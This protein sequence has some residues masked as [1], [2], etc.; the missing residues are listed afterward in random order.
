MSDADARL[1]FVAQQLGDHRRRCAAAGVSWPVTL[2]AAY[3]VASR[4]QPAPEIPEWTDGGENSLMTYAD[5]AARLAISERSL[6]RLIAAGH[7]GTVS[8][9]GAVRVRA[10]DLAAY[11]ATLPLRRS[12]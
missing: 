12:G 6:D 11:I 9:G 5:A 2:E 10:S 4:R 7:L 1:R 3:L 8:V